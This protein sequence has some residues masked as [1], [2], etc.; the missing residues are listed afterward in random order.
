L[1]TL[2]SLFFVNAG[3]ALYFDDG[4]GIDNEDEKGVPYSMDIAYLTA[5][6]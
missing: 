3:G 1:Y 4:E 6:L 5:L 2:L